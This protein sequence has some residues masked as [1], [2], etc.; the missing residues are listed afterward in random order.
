MQY[1]YDNNKIITSRTGRKYVLDDSWHNV[2][3]QIYMNTD[4]YKTYLQDLQHFVCNTV[5]PF[6]DQALAGNYVFGYV[7]NTDQLQ[8]SAIASLPEL[9]QRKIGQNLKKLKETLTHFLNFDR[10]YT[11][12]ILKSKTYS[13]KV[14]N[15][16]KQMVPLE[17]TGGDVKLADEY[18]LIVLY[19]TFRYRLHSLVNLINKTEDFMTEKSFSEHHPV[20]EENPLY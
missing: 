13:L 11:N 6:K 18:F 2:S 7:E 12:L 4:W 5:D 14:S 9:S 20:K 3:T 15:L 10:N 17:L 19:D 8:N 1:I 16:K